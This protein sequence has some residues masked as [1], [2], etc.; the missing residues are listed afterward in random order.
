MRYRL[1]LLIAISLALPAGHYTRLAAQDSTHEAGQEV[2]DEDRALHALQKGEILPLDRV[3]A[4]L[5][6]TIPGEISGLELENE[7]G[8]WIYE[9]KVISPDGRMVEVRVN[10]KTGQFLG[11]AGK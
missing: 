6:D 8:I 9:F 5:H 3:I 11:K 4:R 7:N 10:A 1:I 2:R